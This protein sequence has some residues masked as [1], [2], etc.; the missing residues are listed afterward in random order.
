MSMAAQE[1]IL[2]LSKAGFAEV[3]SALK[4]KYDLFGP[5]IKEGRGMYS[6]TDICLYA[7][8]DSSREL[9][10]KNRSY[11]SSKELAL[12]VSEKLFELSSGGFLEEECKPR[13]KIIFAR[14]CDIEGFARLDKLYLENGLSVDPYYKR[15][16]DTMTF[17]LLECIEGFEGCFCQ[18]VGS[19][20]TEDYAVSLLA[21]EDGFLVSIK[22]ESFSQW[23]ETQSNVEEK[24]KFPE[25][26]KIVQAPL[27]LPD[28]TK[29]ELFEN[30]LWNEYNKRC[31]GC[32][33]CN[34][35]CPTCSCFSI[36][37]TI[38]AQG[39]C[40]RKR[41]WSACQ[42]DGFAKVAGGHEY[43]M[44]KGQRMRY[45]IMHKFHNFKQ[46]FGRQMCVGCGR[47]IEACPEYIDIR[48]S[49]K[50][51]TPPFSNIQKCGEEERA[52]LSNG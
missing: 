40:I 11:F 30:P 20:Q 48:E 8:L 28:F 25:Q 6:D 22:E 23:F 51:L 38:D 29:R 19:D 16:R 37:D 2:L 31:I 47:C 36:Y 18:A 10:L 21:R 4:E 44:D 34:T 5:T 41:S 7:R 45:K 17:F 52:G 33:R 13:K 42:I 32:G 26:G 24:D 3:F 50:R 43:R 15:L 14:S 27:P 12:A 46:R 1:N 49:L 39:N 9:A 35:V